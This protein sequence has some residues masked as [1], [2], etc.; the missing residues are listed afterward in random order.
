[1]MDTIMHLS[2]RR[3]LSRSC[4]IGCQQHIDMRQRQHGSHSYH[5]RRTLFRSG[6]IDEAL[7]MSLS[8]LSV[9]SLERN[10]YTK[11]RGGMGELYECKGGVDVDLDTWA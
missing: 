1:M 6:G 7:W 2:P 10:K 5:R 9:S 8:L 3:C 11:T 4:A